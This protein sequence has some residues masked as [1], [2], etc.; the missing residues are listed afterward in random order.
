MDSGATYER[1]A[2]TALTSTKQLSLHYL[3]QTSDQPGAIFHLTDG[4]KGTLDIGLRP[5][6]RV[7]AD[8]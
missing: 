1:F 5:A 2:K 3:I 6:P 7:V 8:G 4:Q